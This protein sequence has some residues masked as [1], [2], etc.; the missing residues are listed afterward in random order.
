MPLLITTAEEDEDMIDRGGGC[1]L[2]VARVLAL[3]RSRALNRSANIGSSL[4][5]C[6]KLSSSELTPT[7]RP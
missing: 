3:I 5:E 6:D 7:E 1:D 4:P 2:L